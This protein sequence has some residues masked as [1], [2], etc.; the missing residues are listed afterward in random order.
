VESARGVV[1]DFAQPDI[2]T[3]AVLCFGSEVAPLIL[4]EFAVCGTR[5]KKLIYR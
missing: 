3:P 5:S 4:F 2:A 1:I